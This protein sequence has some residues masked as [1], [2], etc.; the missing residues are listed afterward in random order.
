MDIYSALSQGLQEDLGKTDV[1]LTS[2]MTLESVNRF[3][4]SNSFFKK[5]EDEVDK[6]ADDRCM[7]EFI[8][9]NA[10]CKDF[11][12]VFDSCYEELIVGEVKA[13]FDNM[14]F[15]GPELTM[16]WSDVFDHGNVG[17]GASV[18]VV[19]SNFYTKL[20]DSSLSG[21][22][23]LLYRFYLYAIMSNPTWLLAEKARNDKYGHSLVGGNRLS[24]VPKTKEKSRTVCT[25][26]VLN[27]FIQK[28]I[29]A[30]LERLLWRHFKIDLSKQPKRNRYLAR[31]GSI[32]G[33]FGTIDLSSASDTVSLRMLEEVLPPYFLEWLEIS[34][35]PHV[36]FPDGRVEK[37]HMVS[38]MGNGFTFP[39]QT[40]LFSAI[41]VSCYKILGVKTE[42]LRTGPMNFGVFG[43]DIIVRKDC[44]NFVVKALK[45]FGFTTNDHKSF[46]CG[47]FRESCGGDY[48]LGHDVRGFYLRSLRTRANV[49]SA[50]NRIIMWSAKTG[51]L[52]PRVVSLLKGSLGRG[53]ILPIPQQDGDSEG[54][55]MPDPPDELKIDRNTG[56]VIYYAYQNI[57]S[58][59][60]LPNDSAGRK[61]YPKGRGE[62]SFN[63]DGLVISLVG[64]YIRN[65]RISVRSDINRFKVRRRVTS[66]WKYFT[67]GDHLLEDMW[68]T[69]FALYS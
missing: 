1:M 3:Q 46:N 49:Y 48:W 5:F 44:Y 20:F 58:S 41:V 11:Q 47:N 62:I 42:I 35:S 4:L 50:L 55:K 57:G 51:V 38:S 9:N 22:S 13:L 67:A 12:F 36:I 43:D 60:S 45:L 10:K 28:G 68:K 33:S 40:L 27:M 61:F 6:D 30:F 53:K 26:P 59:F 29:G 34:R 8:L 66:S 63:P 39:L 19:S 37:L 64:G 69:V 18:G 7:A 14:F 15:N 32:D 25:E 31:M 2:D 56:G 54:F 21:T 17:P 65:G 23:E 16:K 52:L 24:F